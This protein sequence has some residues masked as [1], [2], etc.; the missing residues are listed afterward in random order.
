MYGVIYSKIMA[1]DY[2]AKHKMKGTGRTKSQMKAQR[3]PGRY[4]QKKEGS[5]RKTAYFAVYGFDYATAVK[6]WDIITCGIL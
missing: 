6:I 2:D 3:N 4:L 1:P 5:C